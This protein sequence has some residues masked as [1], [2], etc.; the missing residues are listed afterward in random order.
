MKG[1]YNLSGRECYLLEF[2]KVSGINTGTIGANTTDRQIWLREACLTNESG[3]WYPL[4]MKIAFQSGARSDRVSEL[5]IEF[6]NFSMGDGVSTTSPATRIY[7]F[8]M[9]ENPDLNQLTDDEI[10]DIC[11][12]KTGYDPDKLSFK[13]VYDNTPESRKDGRNG[14]D[15]SN[16]G[17]RSR[18]VTIEASY[19]SNENFRAYCEI[20]GNDVS[21][22]IS[23]LDYIKFPFEPGDES[24]R[25]AIELAKSK[26]NAT[27]LFAYRIWNPVTREVK[28]FRVVMKTEVRGYVVRMENW[29][30]T[31]IREVR[32]WFLKDLRPF[33][34]SIYN[35]TPLNLSPITL[36]AVLKYDGNLPRI[37]YYGGSGPLEISLVDRTRNVYMM[38]P[39]IR[40]MNLEIKV[41]EPADEFRHCYTFH[42][43]EGNYSAYPSAKIALEDP[44]DC[45]KRYDDFRVAEL[46]CYKEIRPYDVH[47]GHLSFEIEEIV[48]E[49]GKIPVFGV[50][51]RR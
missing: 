11:L 3:R 17:N 43:F 36:C 38:A 1:R 24:G 19:N 21:V 34:L 37:V 47:T 8:K 5:T 30:V 28:E 14:T 41:V 40:M 48:G 45:Y 35:A 26:V 23:K 20:E 4:L 46:K 15:G 16:G 31:E 10:L 49:T 2:A 12:S 29:N 39:A 25:K 33:N 44:E 50:I 51:A 13:R 22:R 9:E 42:L 18:Y 32:L 6:L 7:R 27:P